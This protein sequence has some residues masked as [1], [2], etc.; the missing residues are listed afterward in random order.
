MTIDL[1]RLGLPAWQLVVRTT[2]IYL[3]LLLALRFFGK[4]EIG[5]FTIFDL[6]LILLVANAIQPAITGPDSSLLGGLII[7]AVLFLLNWGVSYLEIH[8]PSLF[9]EAFIGHPTVIAQDGHWLLAAM[10]QQ[11]IDVEDAEM[12]VREHGVENVDGVKLAVLETDGT[13]SVVPRDAETLRT[14]RRV[15]FL[16]PQR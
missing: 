4:R 9:R 11:G 8:V 13:I 1:V 10:R 12:A 3:V 7:I 16:R 6:V 5:Q 14:R 15:R 2:T